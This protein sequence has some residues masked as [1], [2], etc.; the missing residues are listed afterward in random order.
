MKLIYNWKEVLQKAWSIRFSIAAT[1]FGGLEAICTSMDD[2]ILG[3]PKGLLA[4]VGALF[5]AGGIIARVLDQT[6]AAKNA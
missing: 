1:L 4:G 2:S 5:A 3:A 6:K